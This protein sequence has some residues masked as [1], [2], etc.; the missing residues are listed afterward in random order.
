MIIYKSNQLNKIQKEKILKIWN[1]EYPDFLFYSNLEDFEKYLTT[2]GDPEHYIAKIKNNLVGWAVK[3]DRNNEKWFVIMIDSLSQ[4]KGIG[5][6]LLEELKCESMELNG[7]VVAKDI[8]KKQNGHIYKSP[9]R[10]YNKAG[11]EIMQENLENGKL[12]AVKI[13]WMK[14]SDL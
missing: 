14:S 3:F 10:F 6:K 9:I 4:G 12:S 11:F 1:D 5:S 13:K 8:Y 2:L 7:W